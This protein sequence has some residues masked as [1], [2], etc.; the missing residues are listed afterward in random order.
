MGTLSGSTIGF[1]GLG[2]MGRPMSLN[3]KRAGAELVIYNRSRGVVDE[4]AA[5]GMTP[6]STPQD[7]AERAPTVILMVSDTPAVEQVLLGEQGIIHGIKPGSLVIDMG[8]TVVMV[9]RRLAEQVTAKGAE[10]LDA[11]VSGGQIGA[12]D[13]AL[14]IMVGGSDAAFARAKPIFQCL[15]ENITHVGAV[16]AGQVAK[17]A[18]QI[19]VGLT[20]GTVAE[21]LT[22]AKHAGVDPAK[23]REALAGGFAASR[24]LEVHGRRM[25]EGTFEPGAKSTTQRKDLRQALELAKQVGVELP[26]TALN[27]TL[28]ERL[29]AQGGGDLDHSALFKVLDKS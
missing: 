22:L 2:L 18:N 19:I 11:P 16:G 17:A 7:V 25:I 28:Y 9:T 23:V 8:T 21:A 24:I 13:A 5:Q 20:I 3:L 1:V 26:A 4:L 15:G 27:L 10:Y 29:I 12:Q 14:T 6:A